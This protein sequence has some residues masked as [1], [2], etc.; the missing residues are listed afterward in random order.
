MPYSQRQIIERALQVLGKA[1]A[2]QPVPASDYAVVDVVAS[3]RALAA[4]NVAVDLTAYVMSDAIP[5][6]FYFA[7]SQYVAAQHALIFN[8]LTVLE[9][10]QLEALSRSKVLEISKRLQHIPIGGALTRALSG[11][12]RRY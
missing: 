11:H 12:G 2:G 8:A 9:A 7:F 1:E 5:D 4:S 10:E 6:E 3:A